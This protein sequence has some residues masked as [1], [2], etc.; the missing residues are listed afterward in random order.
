[1]RES[2]N[3]MFYITK[4]MSFSFGGFF[5]EILQSPGVTYSIR[6][7]PAWYSTYSSQDETT[8]LLTSAAGDFEG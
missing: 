3:A 7:L 4:W 2:K 6:V 5:G 1:M 8:A